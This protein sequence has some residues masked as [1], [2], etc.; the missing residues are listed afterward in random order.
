[1]SEGRFLRFGVVVYCSACRLEMFPAQWGS[2]YRTR[3]HREAIRTDSRHRPQRVEMD[4]FALDGNP[5]TWHV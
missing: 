1:M 5:M 4:G 2:H 3:V